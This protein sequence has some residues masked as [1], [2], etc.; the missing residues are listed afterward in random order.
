MDRHARP[1]LVPLEPR[2]VQLEDGSQA[3]ALRDPSGVLSH[4]ALVSPG[5]YLVLAHL[6]GTRTLVEVERALAL[7]N[8]PVPL[9]RIAELVR[10]LEEAG[11]LHGASYEAARRRALDQFR[12]LPSRP[13]SCA[14]G[15]YPDDPEELRSFLDGFLAEVDGGAAPL[16]DGVRLLVAPHI[17]LH[18]GGAAYGHAY[19]ALAA[20]AA[21]LFVVFGTAHAS[22]PSLYTLTRLDYDT[23]LGPVT[24]DRALAEALAAEL[25]EE[26][27]FA[28]ELCHRQEH[29]VELQLLWLRHLFPARPVLALPVLCSSISHL[30]D[31]EAATRPF[32]DALGRAVAGRRVCYLAGADLAHV[33]PMYG[34]PAAPT[35][36]ALAAFASQDRRTLSFV[37]RGDAVGFHRDATLDDERR[38]LCGVAP[39]YAA[40]RA[41]G[42]GARLLHYGQWSDGTDSVSFAAAAG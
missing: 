20:S 19:R 14:G 33:G 10:T 7:Q 22:P 28:D 4:S 17:D 2:L 35:A 39:I 37:E 18:R 3:V 11:L 29:S 24:T 32:L 6:D 31:P 8:Q 16:Q 12:A 15:A 40:M 41:A 27:L 5:A 25:G 26:E 23:P 9:A 1:R 30:E 13:A 38:R 42:T 36:E 21:E 34:D